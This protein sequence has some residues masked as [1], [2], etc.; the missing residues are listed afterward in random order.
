[1]HDQLLHPRQ[2]PG[3]SRDEQGVRARVGDDLEVGGAAASCGAVDTGRGSPVEWQ[4][5]ARGSVSERQASRRIGVSGVR[6]GSAGADDAA[7]RG[8]RPPAELPARSGPG[9]QSAPGTAAVASISTIAPSS[10]SAA[11]C[12]SAIAG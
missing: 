6:V 11:T 3:R 5:R 8:F 4:A 9:T 12:T 7:A 10:T 1:M 2:V